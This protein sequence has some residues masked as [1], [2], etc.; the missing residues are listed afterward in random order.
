MIVANEDSVGASS[1]ESTASAPTPL[2]GA[3]EG[4][5]TISV[6]DEAA[7]GEE[8]SKRAAAWIRENAAD[9]NAPPPQVSS[10]EAAIS[11]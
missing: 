6:F 10:G 5:F 2:F 11:F 8:S 7:G 1:P 4:G 9:I 3:G